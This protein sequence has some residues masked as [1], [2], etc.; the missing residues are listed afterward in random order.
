MSNC[1]DD[2]YL[3]SLKEACEI[4]YEKYDIMIS[5]RHLVYL[6][7]CGQIMWVKPGMQ[8]LVY[9]EHLEK[10]IAVSLQEKV[11]GTRGR[12]RKHHTYDKKK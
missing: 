3:I 8:Y 1:Q 2:K 9:R 4:I 7:N 11:K 10:I 5:K 12:N 6:C